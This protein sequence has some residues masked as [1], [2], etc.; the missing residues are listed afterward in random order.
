[1]PRSTVHASDSESHSS[2]NDDQPK[3]PIEE[4][5]G[6]EADNDSEEE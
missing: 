1:M 6:A 3:S 4:E 2:D 5:S